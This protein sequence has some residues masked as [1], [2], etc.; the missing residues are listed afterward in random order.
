M[1]RGEHLCDAFIRPGV[2]K[3]CRTGGEPLVRTRVTRR[4]KMDR[5]P[6]GLRAAR[7]AG[8]QDCDRVRLSRIRTLYMCLGERNGQS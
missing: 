2:K 8:L 4:G 3:L 7:E 1:A 5:T 6:E